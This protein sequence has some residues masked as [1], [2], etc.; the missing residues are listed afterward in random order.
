MTLAETE[1]KK[2]KIYP[3]INAKISRDPEELKSP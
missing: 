3:K 2:K 1:K